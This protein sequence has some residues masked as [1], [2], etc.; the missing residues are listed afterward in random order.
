MSRLICLQKFYKG[1]GVFKIYGNYQNVL[2]L[3]CLNSLIHAVK[4]Y[5][6]SL[7]SVDIIFK[8][9]CRLSSLDPDQDRRSVGPGLGSNC[10]QRFSADDSS[11]RTIK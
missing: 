1:P 7:A 3:D 10:L 4:F 5:T 8:K 6:I 9:E 2:T 11:R